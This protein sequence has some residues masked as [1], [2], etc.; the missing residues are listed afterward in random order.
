MN[1][2]EYAVLA[3]SHPLRA[4]YRSAIGKLLQRALHL[5]V[6]KIFRLALRPNG[7]QAFFRLWVM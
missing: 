4:E 6:P 7:C 2:A 1:V 3:Q 5:R